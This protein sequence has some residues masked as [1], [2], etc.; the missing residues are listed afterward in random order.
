MKNLADRI[1]DLNHAVK[2][3]LPKCNLKMYGVCLPAEVGI[4]KTLSYVDVISNQPVSF[5]KGQ[6]TIF[7]KRERAA[8]TSTGGAGDGKKY[9][10]RTTV[11]MII[12]SDNSEVEKCIT[13][14]LARMEGLTLISADYDPIRTNQFFTRLK[15]FDQQS[16]FMV[17]TISVLTFLK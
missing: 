4:E 17:L 5:A 10:Q 2:A 7:Y 8:F 1:Q 12:N 9:Q 11:S 15:K 3:S 6:T 13:Q 14:E 16:L